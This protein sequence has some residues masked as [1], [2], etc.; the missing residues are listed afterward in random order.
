MTTRMVRI[1][2]ELDD[3]PEPIPAPC[4]AC[5]ER[6]LIESMGGKLGGDPTPTARAREADLIAC[7]ESFLICGRDPDA[8]YFWENYEA[9]WAEAE[10]LVLAAA[11]P[12]DLS[13]V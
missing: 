5:A 7:L 11:D 9:A 12:R 3:D 10:R 4:P 6:A 8:P 1:I 2:A 13:E